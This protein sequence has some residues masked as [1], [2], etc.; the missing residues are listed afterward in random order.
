MYLLG[1]IKG[2]LRSKKKKSTGVFETHMSR[3][4]L[5]QQRYVWYNNTTSLLITEQGIA[6]VLLIDAQIFSLLTY[7]VFV[8]VSRRCWGPCICKGVQALLCL[9]HE[10][11]VFGSN[12]FDIFGARVRYLH[13]AVAADDAKDGRNRGPG[14]SAYQRSAP[15]SVIK[16]RALLAAGANAIS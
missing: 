9:H 11:N 15:S 13:S 16:V 8:M 10:T 7:R 1:V 2:P 3:F 4:C 5:Q 12:T 14:R 6:P